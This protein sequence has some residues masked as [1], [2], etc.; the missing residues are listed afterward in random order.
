MSK[1]TAIFIVEEILSRGSRFHYI[2][3]S[4]FLV[5]RSTEAQ[6]Q[7]D[8]IGVSRL[9]LKVWIDF[10]QIFIED[11]GSKN[12]TK[13][14]D[15]MIPV[16]EPT[17]IAEGDTVQVG[18]Q[19]LIRIRFGQGAKRILDLEKERIKEKSVEVDFRK[20]NDPFQSV[21]PIQEITDISQVVDM[22]EDPNSNS[23]LI[24][25]HN[26][27]LPPKNAESSLA[28]RQQH[29]TS[30]REE[31][32][33]ALTEAEK[34]AERIL[35]EAKSD[36]AKL[37]QDVSDQV[38]I[39]EEKAKE[40][41]KR[42]VEQAEASALEIARKAETDQIQSLADLEGIK[43]EIGNTELELEKLKDEI[44]SSEEER[45]NLRESLSRLESKK[46]K[47]EADLRRNTE[48][49]HLEIKRLEELIH[50][51]KVQ[52]EEKEVQ[53]RELILECEKTKQ[54]AAKAGNM[55][56]QS[57][58]AMKNSKLLADESE[59]MRAEAERKY[60]ELEKE[61]EKLSGAISHLQLEKEQL[62]EKIKKDQIEAEEAIRLMRAQAVDEIREF[63]LQQESEALKLLDEADEEVLK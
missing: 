53:L 4:K 6:L 61:H 35:L 51:L 31:A 54:A 9:H 14:K 45:N 50:Q 16:L 49:C 29:I 2:N 56:R 43:T 17:A 22:V 30:L 25:P 15:D 5:G 33:K 27:P 60:R 32:E 36:A 58:T 3:E 47:V 1:E 23:L 48:N 24:K 18:N 46:D 44:S 20:K 12:G 28:M 59:R 26:P 41:A 7:I 37:K 34:Q 11:Q 21:E 13:W 40:E 63:R 62:V 52:L 55:E 8:E 10:N 39:A 57:L 38:I 42:I 19:Q